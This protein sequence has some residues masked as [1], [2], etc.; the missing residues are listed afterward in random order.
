[1]AGA[2]Q[3]QQVPFVGHLKAREKAWLVPNSLLVEEAD[4]GWECHQHKALAV[5][6]DDQKRL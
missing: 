5:P 4:Q 2:G 3:Q 6:S 1:M